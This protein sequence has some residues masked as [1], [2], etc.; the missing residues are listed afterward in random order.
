M[1]LKSRK[2][3]LSMLMFS[4]SLSATM[5]SI[6]RGINSPRGD[7]K[8][9]DVSE[10]VNL[11][12]SNKRVIKNADGSDSILFN[13]T[14]SPAEAEGYSFVTYLDWS[15][16][17]SD[18]YEYQDWGSGE[19]PY[20]YVTT[21]LDEENK[22]IKLHCL[23]P[24]GR[25]LDYTLVCKEDPAVRASL[26]INYTRKLLNK[27][28]VKFS[29]TKFSEGVP[30]LLDVTTPTYSIGSKGE[31]KEFTAE[32]KGIVFEKGNSSFSTW[33]SLFPKIVLQNTNDTNNV[34]YDADLDGIPEKTSVT[35]ARSK[36]MSR[37]F[38]YL[39][40]IIR[41][42]GVEKFSRSYL[43]NMLSY[44]AIVGNN[45]PS[46]P[47]SEMATHMIA[48][49]KKAFAQGG[50]LTASLYYDNVLVSRNVFEFD[51]KAANISNVSFGFEGVDF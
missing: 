36:M 34:F 4:L 21:T 2:V 29:T 51:F 27:G 3:V 8:Q 31:K 25:T 23:K 41:S 6:T 24:F 10:L 14:V 49:Y 19:D 39:S 26:S 1:K 32:V 33:E 50:G 40:N 22:E 15:S 43:V 30:V 37:A 18:E 7:S 16:Q 20:S 45:S 12:I 47:F 17:E 48:N 9:L 46:Q 11:K 35:N 28:G 13:Y 42:N 5:L 38:L 44:Q